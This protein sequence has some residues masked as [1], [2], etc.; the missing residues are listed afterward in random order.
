M[1]TPTPMPED[2]PRT[3]AEE[4]LMNGPFALQADEDHGRRPV[5]LGD[6]EDV[7]PRRTRREPV[8]RRLDPGMRAVLTAFLLASAVGALA[9]FGLERGHLARSS[10]LFLGLPMLIGLTMIHAFRARTDTGR[11]MQGNVIF[12]AVVA[13][14]LGEASLCILMAMPLFLAVTLVV[15]V[16]VRSLSR[17]T[18]GYGRVHLWLLALPLG[19][20]IAEEHI[21]T[22]RP[23]V[24]ETVIERPGDL[25]SWRDAVRTPASPSTRDTWWTLVGF[26]VPTDYTDLGDDRVRV[27]FTPVEG[28][29][30]HWVVRSHASPEGVRFLME[31]DT[32]KLA[33]WIDVES[34]S[35]DV[36]PG[37]DG[38]VRV[39]QVTVAT[40]LLG[41]HV[42]FDWLMGHALRDAHV[43][44]ADTW[45]ASVGEHGVVAP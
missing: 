13:P 17:S 44:A 14:L 28:W 16:T 42:W 29:D 27:D 5:E 35:V 18:R 38:M 40:P 33:R 1:D 41:P 12:L 20:G 36:L 11:A 39:R 7:A 21:L 3:L 22:P 2:E 43:T 19:L 15:G 6:G 26:P 34:S 31:R 32:T 4:H 9:Y 24:I 37:A 23:V 30:G 8:A 10:A 45:A 25:A